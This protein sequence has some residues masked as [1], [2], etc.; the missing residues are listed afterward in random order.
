MKQARSS[1]FTA[2]TFAALVS[3]GT[4]VPASI[5]AQSRSDYMLGRPK[6]HLTVRAGVARPNASDGVFA[7]TGTDGQRLLTL[8][9]DN[10]AGMSFGGDIGVPLSQRVELQFSVSTASR[11]AESEYRNFEDN[12][13]LPIEQASRLRRTPVSLG[14]RYNLVP[15]G[16]AV[17]RLAWVP[18]KL[19]PY[20]AAGGGAMHYRF[21]QDGDFVDFLSADL[22]VFSARLEGRGWAALGYAA[23]GIT[24]TVVP[25][26]AINTELRYDHSRTPIRGDFT[27]FGNTTLSG[28]GLTTGF[29]FRF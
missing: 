29:Q 11:R 20:V 22:D 15:A 4:C 21:Q 2:V 23:S 10:L 14:V 24:W 5:A 9:A 16:R 1:R 7:V 19:V 26:V 27:G 18:R 6:A 17:S 3:A 28:L 25:A 8:G 13:G 12:R